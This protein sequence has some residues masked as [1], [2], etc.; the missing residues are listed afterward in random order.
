MIQFTFD[1]LSIR[2]VTERI[3]EKF[4]PR[5]IKMIRNDISFSFKSVLKI[6]NYC[7]SSIWPLLIWV[8]T[9]LPIH[10]PLFLWTLFTNKTCMS[11]VHP[12]KSNFLNFP[13]VLT[14][15]ISQIF[16]WTPSFRYIQIYMKSRFNNPI[17]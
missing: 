3:E 12:K 17:P 2:N 6:Q 8:P 15:N 9:A 7:I 16:N 4:V 5:T 14:V 13:C 1:V 11:L 10:F